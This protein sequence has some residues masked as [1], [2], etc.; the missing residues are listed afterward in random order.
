[1]TGRGLGWR[2]RQRMGWEQDT[3]SAPWKEERNKFPPNR[4]GAVL[5]VQAK[6]MWAQ[7]GPELQTPPWGPP[8][9][10][11]P[12]PHALRPEVQAEPRGRSKREWR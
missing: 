7:R 8:H 10:E 6:C 12:W 5:Y 9:W 11:L 1:M 3:I 4:K 2:P